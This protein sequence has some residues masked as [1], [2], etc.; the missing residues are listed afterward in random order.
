MEN[1]FKGSTKPR[2]LRNNNPGNIRKSPTEWQGEKIPSTD[3]EFKQFWSM[4]YGYRA[5]IRLLQNYSRLHGCHTIRRMISRWA[6]ESENN[7]RAYIATVSAAI[8]IGPDE[9]IGVNNREVM[10]KLVAAMSRVENGVPASMDDVLAG[11]N[12]LV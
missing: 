5:M 2:G 8:G 12:L 7:T 3:P 11:W 1:S 10:C 9:V 6:P 4:A